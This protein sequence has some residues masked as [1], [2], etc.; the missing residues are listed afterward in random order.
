[1]MRN[2][3][4]AHSQLHEKPVVSRA[5]KTY[6]THSISWIDH[7]RRSK[8]ACVNQNRS[9]GNRELVGMEIYADRWREGWIG[10]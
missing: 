3:N 1:M 5:A 4:G 6:Y 9:P 2:T 8:R 10:D 7:S